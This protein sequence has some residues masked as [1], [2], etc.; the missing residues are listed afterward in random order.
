M[1]GVSVTVMHIF[2]RDR[3]DW[4]RGDN[5][6]F[7]SEGVINVLRGI[8]QSMPGCYFKRGNDHLIPN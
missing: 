2:A 5:L 3:A 7:Y 6:G 4:G 8:S 1:L